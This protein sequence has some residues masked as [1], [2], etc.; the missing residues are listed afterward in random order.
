MEEG[1]SLSSKRQMRWDPNEIFCMG[2]M[3]GTLFI[4]ALALAYFPQDDRLLSS[5]H[6]AKQNKLHRYPDSSGNN[7][8]G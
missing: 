8:W 3:R 4:D 1:W 6:I 2:S 5:V 7:W